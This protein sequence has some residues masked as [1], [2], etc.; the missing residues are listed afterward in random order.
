MRKKISIFINSIAAGGAERVVSILLTELQ[1]E[2]DIQLVLLSSYIEYRLPHNQKIIFL[3]Q[4]HDGNGLVKLLKLPLL[5]RRYKNICEKNNIDI[6]L[7]FLKRANYINCMSKLMGLKCKIIISERTLFSEYLKFVG[8]SERF[9]GKKLTRF[10]YPKADIIIPNSLLIQADLIT[11]FNVRTK[12]QVIYNPVNLSII[13]NDSIKDVDPSLFRNFT[14]ISV[15]RLSAEK[16]YELLIDAFEKIKHLNCNL[17]FIGKGK[18]ENNLKNKVIIL[19]LQSKIH[20]QG[21]ESN[22]YKYLS[23]A[24][25]FVLS[26]N[27]EG[28][29][30]SIQEALAC[31]LPVVSTDCKSGPREI[32]APDTDVDKNLKNEMEICKYGILVPKNNIDLLAQAMKLIYTDSNLRNNL[33]AKAFERAKDFDSAK[34]ANQFKKLLLSGKE[35]INKN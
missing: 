21:F 3:N 16:N 28:F 19:Q 14:F 12:Y 32:L 29:P 13:N 24:N 5:A 25:C 15:G 22:P 4:K 9:L 20:F 23:K 10:L 8:T 33:Q 6:S 2:F 34:I 35:S 1:N 18:E 11:N 26:S 31:K 30:N 17:L 7:S 27:F